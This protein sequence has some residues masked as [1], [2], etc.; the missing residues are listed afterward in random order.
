MTEELTARKG[1]AESTA[2]AANANELLMKSAVD[3]RL[4][5]RPGALLSNC[6]SRVCRPRRV[7]QD[8]GSAS[9]VDPE[10]SRI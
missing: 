6:S 9:L 8:T 4:Q 5:N 7:D 3:K 10:A 1:K 2:S